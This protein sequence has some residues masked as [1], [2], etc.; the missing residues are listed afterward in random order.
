MRNADRIIVLDAGKIVEEGS[1]EQ[2]I[3]NPE[4]RFY[5]MYMDQRLDALKEMLPPRTALAGKMSVSPAD[6]PHHIV[7]G[8]YDT[9]RKFSTPKHFYSKKFDPLGIFGYLKILSRKYCLASKPPNKVFTPE[10]SVP[11]YF[12]PMK[13]FLTP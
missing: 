10:S 7:V 8:V 12:L 6:M 1:P 2:L 13:N 9:P 4:G 5:R 3:A 11:L